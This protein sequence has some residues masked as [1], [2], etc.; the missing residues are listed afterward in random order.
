MLTK[1]NFF[2]QF[3][4]FYNLFHF[5]SDYSTFFNIKNKNH[6]LPTKNYFFESYLRG[7]TDERIA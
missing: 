6:F 1:N 4:S 7:K 3:L 2:M 5:T